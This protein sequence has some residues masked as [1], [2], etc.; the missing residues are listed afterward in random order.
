MVGGDAGCFRSYRDVLWDMLAAA[1]LLLLY[2][3]WVLGGLRVEAG[4][5]EPLTLL[6]VSLEILV[7]GLLVVPLH[8][9]VH[10]AVLRMRGYHVSFG[11]SMRG[12]IP[13][14]YTRPLKPVRREDYVA[15]SLAPLA[16]LHVVPLIGV[17][18]GLPLWAKM[19]FLYN[20]VGSAGDVLAA[21]SAL[22]LPSGALVRDVGDGFA[23]CMPPPL[24]GV[25]R[26]IVYGAVAAT[27]AAFLI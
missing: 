14:A 15:M 23:E 21:A 1:W 10:A 17:A 22:R 12:G 9:A 2:S 24:Q 11:L 26:L 18:I 16:A 25:S 27:V 13:V 5:A 8:E 7:P 19:L 20:T 6:R 4:G 3:I